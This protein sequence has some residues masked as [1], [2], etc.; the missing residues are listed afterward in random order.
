M[1]NTVFATVVLLVLS[2]GAPLL[3]QDRDM[4]ITAWMSG[5]EMQ[6]ETDFG[7]GITTDFEAGSAMGLSVNR[8]VNRFISVEAAAFDLRSDAGLL[9]DGLT[10][11]GLGTAHL[12]P[13]TV[14]AQFHLAQRS[15]IDP[16]VGAGGAFVLAGDLFSPDLE[17]GGQ[18]RIELD[19]K[20]TWFVNA[21]IGIQVS[22][23]FGLV[24]DGRYVPYKTSSRSNLTG[25]EREI[26]FS[27]RLLSLGLRF[28]F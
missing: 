2:A 26:D 16:Y 11:I 13:I 27:P 21:G 20:L 18:G 15:R 9:L 25:V 1:R 24:L 7:G 8:F 5:V 28:R 14:G 10:P 6:G 23:G 3:A 12:T 19:N 22:G 4:H 17:A